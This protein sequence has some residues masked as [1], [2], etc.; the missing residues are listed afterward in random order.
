M[1]TK[2]ILAEKSFGQ[3]IGSALRVKHGSKKTEVNL[4]NHKNFAVFACIAM[5]T[6]CF[7]EE[8][9]SF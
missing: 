3:D 5:K 9:I 1:S 6:S 4:E 7:K 2:E 8:P